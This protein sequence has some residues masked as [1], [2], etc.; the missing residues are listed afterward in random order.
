MKV[1]IYGLGRSG[2]PVLKLCHSQ[3]HEIVFFEARAEGPDIDEATQLGAKRIST[4]SDT[5]YDLC[6]AAPGVPFDHPDLASLRAEGVE[7]IGEVEWVYRSTD[8]PIIGV[9]GTAGKS[10][11]TLWISEALTRAGRDAPAGGNIDPALAAVAR[12]GATLV[13][14]L[15]SFQLERSPTLRCRTAV[16]LNLGSDHLDRHGSLSKYH[17]A[18]RQ[19]VDNLTEEDLLVYNLDDAEVTSWAQRCRAS[20]RSFSLKRLADAFLDGDNGMLVLDGSPLLERSQLKLSGDHQVANALA[21]AL[22]C[23]HH[24][25]SVHEI[26]RTLAN[27]AGLPGRYSEVLTLGDISYIEDSIATRELAVGAALSTTRPPIVWIGGGEDKGADPTSLQPLIVEKVSLFIGIGA[28]GPYL[29]NAVSN[30]TETLVCP[31]RSG[32]AALQCAVAAATSH[33]QKHH[34][35]SGTVLLAPLAASF[36]QFKDY[37]HRAAVFR[38]TVKRQERQ[39]T[40]CS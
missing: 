15:S 29:S 23:R 5:E 38:Q 4:V 1:L 33:L 30:W 19:L 22:V 35:A 10:S 7:T 31:Q 14:E 26:R 3:R 11:T 12:P 27:F 34:R 2:M 24:G 37:A 20:T 16:L 17:A 6:I 32:E 36:D 39:W 18:K 40:L 8:N 9:S 13:A 25:L 28:S 21:T